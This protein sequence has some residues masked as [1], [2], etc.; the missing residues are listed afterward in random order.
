[1]VAD[2][3]FL[4]LLSFPENGFVPAKVDVSQC[5]VVQALEDDLARSAPQESLRHGVGHNPA[6]LHLMLHVQTENVT[7]IAS[8][9]AA[10]RKRKSGEARNHVVV[11]GKCCEPSWRQP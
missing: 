9:D 1:M 2:Y 7:F 10:M 8:Q 11:F 6:S 4:D 5:H 3:L